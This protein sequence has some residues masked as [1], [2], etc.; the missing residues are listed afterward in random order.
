MLGDNHKNE[1][2]QPRSALQMLLDASPTGRHGHKRASSC[3][4]G[5]KEME[6]QDLTANIK[7]FCMFEPKT[8][9]I[10]PSERDRVIITADNAQTLFDPNACLFVAK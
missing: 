6:L 2:P 1:L 8:D 4:P 9:P 5:F 7:E 3:P 10:L